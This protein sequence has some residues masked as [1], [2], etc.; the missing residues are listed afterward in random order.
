MNKIARVDGDAGFGK[1]LHDEALP[2]PT[3][4]NPFL[5]LELQ[6][7]HGLPHSSAARELEVATMVMR[8]LK[9]SA[10]ELVL[11]YPKQDGDQQLGP[12]PFLGEIG[13]RAPIWQVPTW[14]ESMRSNATSGSTIEMLTD[15][16]APPVPAGTTH[17]GGTWLLRD[18]AACYFRAWA[19][20]RA[21]ARPLEEPEAGI[22]SRE[23]GTAVHTALELI[24][25][26]VQTHRALCA[27]PTVELGEIV[28]S[29][30]RAGVAKT[31]GMGRALEQ[32]RLERL[33]LAWLEI[34]KS[35]PEFTVIESETKH[36]IRIGSLQLTTRADRVDQLE[37]GRYI[38]L[39]YKTGVLKGGCWTGDRPDEPQLPLYCAS[40]DQ[41]IAAA[42]FA[43]IRCGDLGFKGLEQEPRILPNLGKMDKGPL[44]RQQIAEWR[45]VFERLA[46]EFCSGNAL[47]N[48]K[49]KA[50]EYCAVTALCRVQDL[51]D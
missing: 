4:P 9:T 38:V 10:P 24:W 33:L 18:M 48:P 11:S 40:R 42:A 21:G 16:V 6:R 3:R 8:R 1:G 23:S 20:N 15:P 43:Q 19:V 27:L 34:E 35:R 36:E 2:G 30:V 29:S 44:L 13:N 12:S 31:K 26:R 28:A 50:C 7:A 45:Q 14:V 41:D 39:D 32:K 51:C 47:V 25:K 17:L 5:P 22:T 37:D 46:G 49:Q